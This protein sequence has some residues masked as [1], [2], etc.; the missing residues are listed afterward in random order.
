[1]EDY[2]V[3]IIL[4]IFLFVWIWFSKNDLK[5]FF[6][7]DVY[8]MFNIVRVPLITILIIIILALRIINI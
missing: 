8:E 6:W 5:E 2:I 7:K 1:M 3:L 4:S